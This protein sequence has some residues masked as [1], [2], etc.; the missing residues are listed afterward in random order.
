LT[1]DFAS[2]FDPVL[3]G[4]PLD[5]AI[6]AFQAARLS[7]GALARI[8]I[9]RAGATAGAFGVMVTFPSGETRR[10]APGL[11]SIIA[12][13]A[14]ETF[15]PRFLERAAVLWLS[16]SGAHV[17]VRDQA[18][19]A[20][21]G[22]EIEADKN[23][24]D[25]VFADLGP[26]EPLIVFVELVASDGAVTTRRRDA[27][28]A[29]ADRAGFSRSRVAF[30]TAFLDRRAAGF[31]KTVAELAWGSYAWFASEPG[32]IIALYDGAASGARLG[33]LIKAAV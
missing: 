7:A 32:Q 15:A 31:R 23:L 19:A 11:S 26:A 27:L 2:L 12:K 18:I 30:V 21:I 29:I 4:K 28:L 24:P 17:V 1:P 33:D 6:A 10:L 20:S 5:E 13:A 8:A 16:E 9:M 22:L 3:K 14:I 25:L